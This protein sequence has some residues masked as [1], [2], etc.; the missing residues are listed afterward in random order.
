MASAQEEL[1]ADVTVERYKA[2][3]VAKGFSQVEGIDNNEVYAPV[4]KLATLRA[5]LAVANEK[6]LELEHLDVK[7]VFLYGDLE[8]TIYMNLPEGYDYQG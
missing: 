2:R 6:D 5:L 4:S 7:N 1:K 3:L 8:E